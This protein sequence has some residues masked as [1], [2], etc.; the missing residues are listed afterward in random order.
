MSYAL[1][2]LSLEYNSIA[3]FTSIISFWGA[4]TLLLL[5]KS[6]IC[7]T[8]NVFPSISSE[9]CIDFILFRFR[10]SVGGFISFADLIS[11]IFSEMDEVSFNISLVIS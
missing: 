7:S 8:V 10:N 9:D 2:S 5:I 4:N 11:P 3:F 1:N 6:V